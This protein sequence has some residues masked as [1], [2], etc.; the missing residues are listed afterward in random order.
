MKQLLQQTLT[1]Q[2]KL[3]PHLRQAIQLL[4][5]STIELRSKIQQAIDA[6][7]MLEDH[8]LHEQD[9]V[10]S[11]SITEH[12]E[13][14][15]EQED[16]FSINPWQ[17]SSASSAHDLTENITGAAPSLQEH[18]LWQLTMSPISDIDLAI[19]TALI[20]A[21]DE[22][23]FLTLSLEEILA[24][25]NSPTYP[26]DLSEII[27][28][29]KRIQRLDPVGCACDNLVE[30]LVVQ[31]EQLP[32][33]TPHLQL[34]R[35]IILEDLNNLGYHRANI[36][37][38]YGI[39]QQ[40]LD[41]VHQNILR[42]KP[43]PGSSL[44]HL[45]PQY[46]TPD[47]LAKKRSTGWQV[48]LNPQALPQLHINPYYAAYLHQ[49][50]PDNHQAAQYLKLNLQEA[51]WLINS[52]QHRQ[53]TILKVGRFL[54]SYQQNFLEFGESAMRP[55]ILEDVAQALQLHP[56]TV[57]RVTN[58][59]YIHTPRG[60]FE[61]KYFFCN[62]VPT[63]MGKPCSSVAIR[64]FIKELIH[65]E[66]HS[67]PLSDHALATLMNREGIQIARRTVTKYRESMGF[68]SSNQ[69]KT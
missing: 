63:T 41:T 44:T 11:N 12:L 52:L 40:I 57:S 8:P 45:S 51:Q 19:A 50:T 16:I 14:S 33:T 47:L 67:A 15:F 27:S 48:T 42:L 39:S 7:P 23:G 32:N 22:H 30:T 21:L 28:V 4:R 68:A 58:Q 54:V 49:L 43:K 55:L 38:K 36:L 6:N 35:S 46:L 3:T 2:L 69:R 5:L 37:K 60:L 9:T 61:L 62:A 13:D 10:S 1:P 53:E 20:D 59:K 29:K 65:G 17:T 25:L 24:S 56:S 31:L 26:L 34:T 18:L 64:A 66:N